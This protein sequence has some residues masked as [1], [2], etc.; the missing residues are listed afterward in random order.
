MT[1]KA[2]SSG[3]VIAAAVAVL[4][5]AC[6]STG[7][8]PASSDVKITSCRTDAATHRAVVTGAIH[9]LSSKRSDYVLQATVKANDSKIESGFA[10]VFNVNSGGRATFV[11]HTVGANVPTGTTL[12]CSITRVSRIAG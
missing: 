1:Q 9:N 2:W 11:I 12:S 4:T 5:T 8:H 7:S 6:S 3:A 10:S